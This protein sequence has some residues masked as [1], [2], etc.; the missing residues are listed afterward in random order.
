M[1]TECADAVANEVRGPYV[2]YGHSIGALVAYEVARILQARGADGPESLVLSGHI[3]PQHWTGARSAALA[4]A[5]DAELSAW[6]KATGGAPEAVL[7]NPDLRAMAVDLLR[8]DLAAYATYRYEPE[9]WLRAGIHLLVGGAESSP[10][11]AAAALDRAS[12]GCGDGGRHRR[13]GDGP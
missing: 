6:L 13:G 7:A 2:L 8:M 10:L 11:R 12:A 5:P 4:G 9:E 3:A 1:V